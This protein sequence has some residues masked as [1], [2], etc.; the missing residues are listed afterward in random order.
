MKL[1]VIMFFLFSSVAMAATQA[2]LS[3]ILN[4]SGKQRMLSQR[5]AKSALFIARDIRTDDSIKDMRKA[6]SN[7]SLTLKGLQNGNSLLGIV[8]VD[9]VGIQ[10]QLSVVAKIW[11]G[12]EKEIKVVVAG[13]STRATLK[14][15]AKDS[16]PLLNEMSKAVEMYAT[17]AYKSS[18]GKLS[19]NKATAINLSGKQRMLSQKMTKELL[20]VSLSLGKTASLN[21]LTNTVS[22]FDK[23]L[24]GL[25]E[26]EPSLKLIASKNNEILGQLGKV[27]KIWKLYQPI[28][29]SSIEDKNVDATKLNKIYTLNTELLDSMNK[30]VG[31]IEKKY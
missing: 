18:G 20:Q 31:L 19:V 21:D 5:I 1:V 9:N 22:L 6:M 23:T 13:K 24:N 29:Q 16:V 10:Q 14:K 2:E 27:K 25:I 3:K 7:F 17:E 28:L 8:K 4:L 12:F 30:A 11:S 26:G 15:I